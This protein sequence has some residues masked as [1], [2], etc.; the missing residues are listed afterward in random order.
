MLGKVHRNVKFIMAFIFISLVFSIAV[1]AAVSL[2]INYQGRL[3]NDHGTP[4]DDGNYQIKFKIYSA[5]KGDDSLWSSGFQ[6]VEVVD[7]LFEYLLGSNVSFPRGIFDDDTLRYLGVTVG[8]ASEMAPRKRITSAAFAHHARIADNALDADMADSAKTLRGGPYLKRNGDTLQGNLYLWEDQGRIYT[9]SGGASLVFRDEG[10][11]KAHLYGYTF[12][13]MYLYNNT[14]V[15]SAILDAGLNSGAYLELLDSDSSVHILID[16]NESGDDAAIFPDDAV[17]ADEMLNEP[18]IASEAGFTT[19]TLDATVM[20]TIETVT[21]TIPTSGYIVV[22]AKAWGVTLGTTGSNKGVVQIDETAGGSISYPYAVGFG[23][24]GHSSTLLNYFPLFTQRVYN[25]SAGTY[26]FLLEGQP[27][28]SN[29]AGAE[30]RVLD[31]VMLVTFYPSSYESVTA[32]MSST[33]AG[34]FDEVEIETVPDRGEN[35][36]GET[37]YKLTCGN[38]N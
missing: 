3:T 16:A 34:Q 9:N 13:T 35:D 11:E 5:A 19:I 18:G 4:V 36:G 33:E 37:L 17:N 1:K 12:G 26:T 15:R 25:K 27:Y 20:E 14:G 30:V 10:D 7:G 21:I 28:A 24:G 29:A 8:T 2:A 22:Q 6:S 23:L 31:P 38:W 32:Y